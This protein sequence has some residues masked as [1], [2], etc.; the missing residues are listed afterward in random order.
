MTGEP[1]SAERMVG[2]YD[3]LFPPLVRAAHR[4][5]LEH[6]RLTREEAWPTIESCL[7]FATLYGVPG[8]ELAAFFGYLSY[9]EAGRTIWVDALRGPILS[10]TARQQSTRKQ[11]IAYGFL[12][13]FTETGGEGAAH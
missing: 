9:R 11:A 10:W 2:G 7:A 13:A 8:A 6:A 12:C 5:C 4:A 3:V 1:I